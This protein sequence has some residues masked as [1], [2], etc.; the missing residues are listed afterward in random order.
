MSKISG[1]QALQIVDSVLAKTQGTREDHA[2]LQESMRVLAS[3]VPDE[4]PEEVKDQ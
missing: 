4:T 1:Q 3:L 2:I